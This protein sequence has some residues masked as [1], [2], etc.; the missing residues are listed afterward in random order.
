M[1]P[2]GPIGAIVRKEVR[3]LARDGRLRV[4]GGIIAVL[5]LSALI[6]GAQQTWQ[7]QQARQ[8]AVE[9]A[10][11][12]WEGQGQ[13]NP[14]VAAHYGT[15]VFAPTS[16]ATAIDPGVSAA[17]GRS[18]RIEAHRRNLAAHARSQDA[19]GLGGMG[20][21]SITM[22]LL[23]LVPLLIIALGYGLWGRERE[24]GTLR[25]LVSTG[26]DLRAL[27]WGKMLALALV[28]GAVVV[29]TGAVIT[30]A[31]WALGGGDAATLA[32]LGLL[33]LGYGA[34]FLI[35]AGLT[36]YASAAARSSR[37]ALVAMIGVWGVFCLLTPRAATEV[38]SALRPLP[39]QAAFARDVA[40]SLEHGIDGT[41]PREQAVGAIT[42]ELMVNNGFA[43][44]GI[45]V[46][47][48]ALNGF[49]L[50][51]EARWEDAIYDHHVKA[52]EDGIA[53][54]ERAVAWAGVLSPFVAMRSLSAGLCGTDYAHHRHFTDHAE[55][56]RKRLIGMLNEA[57]AKNAGAQG[58]DYRAGAELW[59]QAPP[60]EYTPPGPGFALE[61]HLPAVASL[62]G[63]MLLALV[64]ALR[65]ARRVKVTA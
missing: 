52:L 34:Y 54:Q 64:L 51:A 4:L 20:A 19:S 7:A 49:E 38:A 61:T 57:F 10:E 43:T 9:R 8:Q 32:R 35:F 33:T 27:L 11:A 2:P 14:H 42:K 45:F 50:Q 56:W 58:W 25:Q 65:S 39:S 26:V 18:V 24:R 13:R 29:P 5:A 36:L 40:Q 28:V 17:L 53:A 59:K 41:T 55:A 44:A 22:V 3:E 1:R 30:A 23:L 31:L 60:L 46:D 48:A 62:L 63:W 12:D 6:F 15:H 21:F 37:A 47:E 16:A